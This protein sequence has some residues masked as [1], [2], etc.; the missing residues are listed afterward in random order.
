MLAPQQ[1]VILIY[2]T[3][4]YKIDLLYYHR[5]RHWKCKYLLLILTVSF[6]DGG[7]AAHENGGT[8]RRECGNHSGAETDQVWSL[9]NKLLFFSLNIH[10]L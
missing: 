7:K 4:L 8:K 6:T 10:V 9:K 3:V 1:C 5:K 2:W